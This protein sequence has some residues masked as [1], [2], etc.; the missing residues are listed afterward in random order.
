MVNLK[1]IIALFVILPLLTGCE[2]EAPRPD[3]LPAAKAPKPVSSTILLPVKISSKSIQRRLESAI[4][5]TQSGGEQRSTGGSIA[6]DYETKFKIDREKIDLHLSGSDIS[7]AT[8]LSGSGNVVVPSQGFIPRTSVTMDVAA[9]IGISSTI[10]IKPDWSV[11]ASTTSSLKV[12]KANTSI[13][14]LPVTAVD[15]VEK[16]LRPKMKELADNVTADLNAM[17]VRTPVARTWKELGKP[18]LIDEANSGW[19]TFK[20]GKLYFSGFNNTA[21]GIN[22]VF[23]VDAVIEGSYGPKPADIDVGSL[24]PF[25]PI[26]HAASGFNI[27]LPVFASY[28]YLEAS[29]KQQAVGNSYELDSG[30]KVEIEDVTL[31]GNGESIVLMLDIKAKLPGRWFDTT[32]RIYFSGKPVFDGEKERLYMQGFDYDLKTRSY[33]LQAANGLFH[34]DLRSH[35]ADKL[36]WDLSSKLRD[37][38]LRANKNLEHVTLNS[39]AS[40]RGTLFTMR[41]HGVYPLAAGIQIGTV[42][43]GDMAVELE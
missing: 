37:A 16:A 43:K 33:L 42:L 12:T 2:I 31:Y 40:L 21:A 8:L 34:E 5:T 1:S 14:G 41:V 24:P 13:L 27:N 3:P 15:D 23:G 22:A 20:P 18:V 4:P 38:K 30:I 17:D 26:S 25:Q 9:Y 36:S 7:V 32:G 10:D 29:L 28:S 39:G 6:I 35:I 19:L 11:S